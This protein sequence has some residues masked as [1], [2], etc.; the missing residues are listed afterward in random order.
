MSTLSHH[1]SNIFKSR[2]GKKMVRSNAAR[3]V[4]AV[5][6]KKVI[7]NWTISKHPAYAVGKPWSS[8]VAESAI[9]SFVSKCGPIPTVFGFIN[10]APKT[11]HM[12]QLAWLLAFNKQEKRPS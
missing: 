9:T 11:I 8:L 3:I 6:N 2:S 10:F 4:T 12:N 1:V 5:T 7:G